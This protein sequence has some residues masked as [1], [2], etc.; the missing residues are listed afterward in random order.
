MME[1]RPVFV[2]G[3]NG[4]I[5]SHVVRLLLEGGR[6]VRGLIQPGS[7]IR[8][9]AALSPQLQGGLE[10]IEGDLRDRG[11]LDRGLPGCG[12]VF[13]LAAYNN[14]WSPDPRV[15]LSVN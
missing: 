14:L 2:T 15:P 3:A 13:H 8:N 6:S 5:G 4:F 9:L 10:R 7:S 11:V 12:T 1:S